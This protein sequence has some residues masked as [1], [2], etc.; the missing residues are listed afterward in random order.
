ML[1][2]KEEHNLRVVEDESIWPSLARKI[3]CRAAVEL[4]SNTPPGGEPGREIFRIVVADRDPEESVTFAA[5]S[6]L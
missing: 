2:L 6:W 3:L 4:S 1:A 5:Y